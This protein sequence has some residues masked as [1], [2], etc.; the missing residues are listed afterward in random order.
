MIR[1]HR[2]A[3][4]PAQRTGILAALLGLGAALLVVLAWT[5]GIRPAVG[6]T[7][8]PLEPVL[9]ALM[10]GAAELALLHIE[11]RREAYSFSLSG[12]PIAI[13]ALTVSPW[14]LVVARVVGT[15]LAFVWQRP[16]RQKAAYNLLSYA[17][18]AGVVAV[19]TGAI[20]HGPETLNLH[21]GMLLLLVML[22]TDAVMSG[23]VLKVIGWHT[24]S[25]ERSDRTR[26][27]LSG[28]IVTA[29]TTLLGLVVLIVAG[30]GWLG[31]SVLV[32]LVAVFVVVHRAY[33]ALH[34]RHAS[35]ELVH[36]FVS[37]DDRGYAFD[38][39]VD[40]SLARIAA[41]LRAGSCGMLFNG[42]EGQRGIVEVDEAGGVGRRPVPE[43][44]LQE[45]LYAAARERGAPIVVP[46]TTND[47]GQRAWLS[48]HGLR[49]AIVVPVLDGDGVLGTLVVADRQG[50]TATFGAGDAQ[51]A[52]TLSAHMAVALRNAALVA[53]LRLEATHDALTGIG[54]RA[55]LQEVM[56]QVHT[57]PELQT[58]LAALLLLDLDRFKDVNDVLGHVA[59]DRLLGVVA[60][61]LTELSS[62][63]TVVRLGGDE[64]A[65]LLTGLDDP[66][67]ARRFAEQ[68]VATLAKPINLN[69]IALS[70]DASVGVTVYEPGAVDPGE[71]LRQADLAMYGVK[72]TGRSV[73]VYTQDMERGH[74]ERL[75]LVSDLRVA[76]DRDELFMLYQPKQDLRT[77]RIVGV[78]ALIRWRHPRLG[79]LSP[80][81]FISLAESTGLIDR[82]TDTA[83]RL[84]LTQG[85]RWRDAGYDLS[86]AVNL[87]AHNLLDPQL[88]ARVRDLLAEAG[89]PARA[90]VLE[91]TEGSVVSE[92]EHT[93][94][95]IEALAE[96]GC[97]LSLDDFGTGYSSLSYLQNLP[98]RE[99]KIDRSFITD[100][101]GDARRE[102]L[103]A[104]IIGL[105]DSLR[106]RV[107]AE[108]IEDQET[109]DHLRDMGC[110]V[111]QGYFL[112]PPATPDRLAELL[113]R[114]G[115]RIGSP[116][117][118]AS[119]LLVALQR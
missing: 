29:L 1:R 22:A 64:F 88:P 48:R 65:I 63:S 117:A 44:A 84:A 57:F 69:G 62:T 2:A 72:G 100:F 93:I 73:G 82:V 113:T 119:R 12:V 83:L 35:L 39:L 45:P 3:L 76:L 8:L 40:D 13:G 17:F 54:N 27:F 78:E 51:V 33:A 49:D 56:E 97:C 86:V 47:A 104:A 24:S 89:L 66:A 94:P 28:T 60:T 110:D 70:A 67:Q 91:I 81:V 106:L 102:A 77:N 103:V 58:G 26:V 4:G 98:V 80:D 85:R 43:Q 87:S 79:V 30:Y 96:L 15:L 42:W 116:G 71:L 5:S 6:S 41:S 118:A 59:G 90:L 9:L 23:L 34:H 68:A 37:R 111:V 21:V 46:R 114:R 101:V 112:S 75:A 14:L 95:I 18:E 36:E 52:Q 10:F 20:L 108:G 61:R 74:A 25:L 55:L 53:R 109:E 92:P 16:E 32:G 50:E 11:F 19:A 105:G 7:R 99:V 115:G 38:E 31:V 107:V